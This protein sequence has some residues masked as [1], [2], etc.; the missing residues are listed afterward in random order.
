MTNTKPENKAVRHFFL[1]SLIFHTILLFYLGRSI[2]TKR[3]NRRIEVDLKSLSSTKPIRSIPTPYR[4]PKAAPETKKIKTPVKSLVPKPVLAHAPAKPQSTQRAFSKDA[5]E[6]IQVPIHDSL[7]SADAGIVGQIRG[8]AIPQ[9][10]T[11]IKAAYDTFDQTLAYQ[12]M[13]RRRLEEHKRFPPLA[14]RRG[15]EGR[16]GIRFLLHR[17]GHVEQV[18]VI[19]SSNI[20]LLD[21]AALS[22]VHDGAPFPHFPESIPED[23]LVIEVTLHFELRRGVS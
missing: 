17:D 5:V 18:E 11:R 13:V 22:A 6:K 2:L 8:V 21:K 16:V 4:R 14:V 20:S 15:L 9:V 7:T 23:F 19:K 3:Y 1:I 12:G 10:P